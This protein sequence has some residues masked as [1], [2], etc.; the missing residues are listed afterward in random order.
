MATTRAT[1]IRIYAPLLAVLVGC[2]VTVEAKNKPTPEELRQ[3]YISN[4]EQQP[5]A[6]PVTRTLGS[7]WSPSAPLGNLS[8]DIRARG[9]NDTITIVVALQTSAQ[10]N[11]NLTSQRSFTTQS[12]I[13]GLVAQLSTKNLNP[14]LAANS[15]T[16]LQGKGQTEAD[17]QLTTTL[18]GRVIAV[19]P[20]GNLV[21]EAQRQVYMNNQH[22]TIIVRGVVQP[23]D[24]TANNAVLSTAMGSLQIEMKGKGIISDST[25]PPNPITRAILWLFGF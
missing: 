4:L 22:E 11:G 19:L 3:A 7:L 6:Q 20:N 13:T 23:A 1:R 10:S 5:G 18:T 24:I 17:S 12:G 15:S 25:R 2:A 8:A 21:V 16:Q 9:L 14:L